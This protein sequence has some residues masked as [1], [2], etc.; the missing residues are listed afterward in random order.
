MPPCSKKLGLPDAVH[1]EEVEMELA[2]QND[3]NAIALSLA[4]NWK[5]LKSTISSSNAK[6]IQDQQHEAHEND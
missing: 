3:P 2:E 4:Y 1:G 5:P 6:R